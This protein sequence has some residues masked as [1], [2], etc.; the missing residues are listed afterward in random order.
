VGTVSA[1]VGAVMCFAQ[2]HLKRLLAFSTI[3]HMGLLFIGFALLSPGGMAGLGV[4]LVGH[5][6]AKAALFLA[7]GILLHRFQTVN[8]LE[9]RGACRL[10]PVT[11]AISSSEAWPWPGCRRSERS[12]EL[13]DWNRRRKNPVTGGFRS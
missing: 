9:L 6:L 13:R 2:I 3:S 1:L 4:Y 12:S 8:E 7:T 10:A 5:S 11:G